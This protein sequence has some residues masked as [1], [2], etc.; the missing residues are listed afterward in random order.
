MNENC[1]NY[2]TST[3]IK[4]AKNIHRHLLKNDGSELSA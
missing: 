2:L 4:E 1:T 3:Q